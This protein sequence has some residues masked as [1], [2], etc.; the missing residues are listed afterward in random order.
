MSLL[1]IDPGC[2]KKKEDNPGFGLG[3]RRDS[4]PMN[5]SP[6]IDALTSVLS[7]AFRL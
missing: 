5:R 4:L 7:L 2:E 3:R 6:Q 1:E